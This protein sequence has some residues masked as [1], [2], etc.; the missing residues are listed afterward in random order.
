MTKRNPA[1]LATRSNVSK[2]LEGLVGCP[3][4]GWPETRQAFRR[5]ADELPNDCDK[6]MLYCVIDAAL[7]VG[8][9]GRYQRRS[10]G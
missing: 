5:I 6:Q 8:P 4:G 10:R 1:K 7:E 9:T 3:E 2:A